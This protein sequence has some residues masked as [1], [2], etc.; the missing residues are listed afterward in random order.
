MSATT[1]RSAAPSRRRRCS[2][3]R[4]IAPASIPSGISPAMPGSCRPMPMPGSTSSTTPT[5]SRGRS[6]RRRAGPCAAQVLRAGRRRRERRAQG[7]K[8]TVIS[9]LALEAVRRI[10]A[11]F[12]RRARRSTACRAEAAPGRAPGAAV[13]RSSTSCEAWMRERARQALA[14]QRRRQ[15][16]G[17]H[18]Q[19]LD[20]FTRFL[21]DGRICLTQQRR[22]AR[23][24]R[25][26]PRAQVWL[27]AG[28]DRGGERAAV[29]LHADRHRQA[30]RRRPA[31]LA[32]R[33]ARPHR[34]SSRLAASTS[35]C[36]GTG[37]SH[38]ARRKLAA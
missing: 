36:P 26:C 33:R 5:A 30:Q 9:P 14:P 15:G 2:S 8:P 23:A 1:G 18:A 29:M 4:A 17:L 10:D 7:K 38:A 32:R 21:D 6:P 11:I 37:P 24:A 27:F 35:S 28:S 34:R 31:G 19:A 13:R 20:A 12:A 3:T 25:H 16:H 22:R